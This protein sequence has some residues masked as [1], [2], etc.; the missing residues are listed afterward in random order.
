PVAIV[1]DG[2]W[3]RALGASDA[4]L[5][6]SV[7]VGRVQVTVIGV[8]PPGFVGAWSDNESDIW[9]P[10]TMQ[11]VLDYQS[12]NSAYGPVDRNRSWLDQDGIAWLNLFARIPRPSVPPAKAVLQSTNRDALLD[13]SLTMPDARARASI[14]SGVLVVEP[15]TRGFSMLRDRFA[16]PLMVLTAMV[17]IVLIVACANVANLLL[18]RSTARAREIGIRV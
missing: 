10:L 18:A 2:Y 11:S 1:S 17:A 4:A 12:N 5:G 8:A 7:R 13:L 15:F 6:R 16:T 3:K 9:M 14:T